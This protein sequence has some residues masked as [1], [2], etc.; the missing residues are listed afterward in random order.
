MSFKE[1]CLRRSR[2]LLEH[3]IFWSDLAQQP[4]PR[5]WHAIRALFDAHRRQG[6]IVK[7]MRGA[8]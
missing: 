2:Q 1:M 8:R 3:S 7:L 6:W 5:R 4:T